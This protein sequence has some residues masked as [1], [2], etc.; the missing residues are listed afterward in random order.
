M[1]SPGWPGLSL[2]SLDL[3]IPLSPSGA[4]GGGDGV[5]RRVCRRGGR[6]MFYHSI[7]K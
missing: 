2:T 7:N 1:Y 5:C 3:Q 6:P 4:A